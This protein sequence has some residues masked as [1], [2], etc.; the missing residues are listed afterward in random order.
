[1]ETATVKEMLRCRCAAAAE[2]SGRRRGAYGL[3]AT[4]VAFYVYKWAR[5]VSKYK[6]LW[7]DLG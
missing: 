7:A 6:I 4:A 5:L 1:V 3:E 2:R